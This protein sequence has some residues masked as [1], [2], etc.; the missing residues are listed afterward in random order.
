MRVLANFK[1]AS[2]A[3]KAFEDGVKIYSAKDNKLTIPEAH[4]VAY[5][6]AKGGLFVDKTTASW[7]ERLFLVI[8]NHNECTSGWESWDDWDSYFNSGL[9]PEEAYRESMQPN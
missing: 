6:F 3:V 8:S 5:H 9:S 2:D 4:D 1:K 7:M